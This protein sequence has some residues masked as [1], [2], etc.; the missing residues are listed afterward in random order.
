MEINNGIRAII[1]AMLP[2]ETINFAFSLREVIKEYT[3]KIH[4]GRYHFLGGDSPK[5]FMLFKN[6][7]Y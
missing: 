7:G 6:R 3:T 1:D 5:M 4:P 2:G